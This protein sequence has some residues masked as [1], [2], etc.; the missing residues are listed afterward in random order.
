LDTIIGMDLLKDW[1]DIDPDQRT[2]LLARARAVDTMRAW[3]ENLSR[4]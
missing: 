1:E 3:E 4:I 2:V